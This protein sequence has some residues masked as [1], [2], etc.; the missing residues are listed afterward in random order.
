MFHHFTFAEPALK[1]YI[2]YIDI[3][4]DSLTKRA[5]R[6]LNPSIKYCPKKPKDVLR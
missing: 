1:V 3:H 6:P 2:V 4:L 5:S